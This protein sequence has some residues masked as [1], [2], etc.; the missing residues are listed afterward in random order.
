MAIVICKKEVSSLFFN[1]THEAILAV[2]LLHPIYVTIVK[3][4]NFKVEAPHMKSMRHVFFFFF[5][6]KFKKSLIIYFLHITVDT[7]C[8]NTYTSNYFFDEIYAHVI[9][10]F[11]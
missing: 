8:S 9:S 2:K 3:K 10:V 1:G 4:M 7:I 6:V 11:K 5:P